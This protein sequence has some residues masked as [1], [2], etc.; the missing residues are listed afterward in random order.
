M[1]QQQ[2]NNVENISQVNVSGDADVQAVSNYE[3]QHK[4][5]EVQMRIHASCQDHRA[6]VDRID[7]DSRGK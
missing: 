4:T 5:D 2:S 7:L 1:Q 6:E 3:T